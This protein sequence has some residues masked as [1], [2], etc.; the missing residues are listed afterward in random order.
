M[1]RRIHKASRADNR[2]A[3]GQL[4]DKIQRHIAR[5]RLVIAKVDQ[6]NLN[7]YFELGLAMGMKMEVLLVSEN[8][9]VLSLPSDLRNWECLTFDK[10]NFNQLAD[11]LALFLDLT[12]GIRPPV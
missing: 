2:V 7:V 10:G 3:S 5:S 1:A 8:S 12:Y 9:L 6:E 11:R 4:L